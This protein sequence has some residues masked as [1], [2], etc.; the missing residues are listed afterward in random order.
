MN[1]ETDTH[2]ISC[3]W[4]TSR[5]RLR[6]AD[7]RSLEVIGEVASENGIASVYAS[8]KNNPGPGERVD[9]YAEALQNPIEALGRHTGKAMEGLPV[10]CSGMASSSL[11]ISELPYSDLPFNLDGSNARMARFFPKLLANPLYLIS[12][13]KSE[14]DVMR[15]EETELTGLHMQLA[16]PPEKYFTIVPGTHSKHILVSRNQIHG[17]KTFMTGE[18]FNVLCSSST[19]GHS[20]DTSD[21]IEG[22]AFFNGLDQG[23]RSC[24]SQTLF[25]VRVNELLGAMDKRQNYNFLSGLLIGAELATLTET[26]GVPLILFGNTRLI[27]LYKAAMGHLGLDKQLMELPDRVCNMA[28]LKGQ[29]EIFNKLKSTL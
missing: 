26:S 8:F 9:Y 11:G 10:I 12:G 27:P 16:K 24:L 2:F 21:E 23:S 3:D 1:I 5:L 20:V 28:V 25:Q 19:L 6:L 14:R 15:G 4:G 17:F 7:R 29:T 22:P 18:L 13:V